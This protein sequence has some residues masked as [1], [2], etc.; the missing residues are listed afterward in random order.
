VDVEIPIDDAPLPRTVEKDGVKAT[1]QEL[2]L[3]GSGA[4]LLLRLET[5]PSGVVATIENDGSY[6]VGLSNKESRAASPL[7]GLVNQIRPSLVEYRLGFQNVRGPLSALRVQ[8]MY[9]GGARRVHPFR[10]EHV[11][12]PVDAPRAEPAAKR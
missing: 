10:I 12:I 9:R 11:P 5:D 3:Q 1:L 2:N 6:G 8:V 4:Q 7:G